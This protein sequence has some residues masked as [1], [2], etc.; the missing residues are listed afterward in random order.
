MFTKFFFSQKTNKYMC[1]E[2]IIFN[3][4]S[5]PLYEMILFLESAPLTLVSKRSTVMIV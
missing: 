3:L 5:D 2:I 1:R 4:H